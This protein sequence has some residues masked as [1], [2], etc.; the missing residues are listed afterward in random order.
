MKQKRPAPLH[1]CTYCDRLKK[2]LLAMETVQ[3]SQMEKV[4]RAELEERAEY[5]IKFGCVRSR[6]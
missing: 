1:A 4:I 6:V 3:L 5:A 2:Q